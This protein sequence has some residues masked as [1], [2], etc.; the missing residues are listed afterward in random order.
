MVTHKISIIIHTNCKHVSVDLGPARA[1]GHIVHGMSTGCP[2]SN[3]VDVT[4]THWAQGHLTGLLFQ[5]GA[6]I[7]MDT[8]LHPSLC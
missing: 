3:A 2:Q 5:G 8:A 6:D 1:Y 4:R 7:G